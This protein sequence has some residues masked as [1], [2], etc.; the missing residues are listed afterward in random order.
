LTIS[1]EKRDKIMC[2][3][4]NR[5]EALNALAPEDMDGL[6]KA[7]IGF[8]DDP[9]AWVCILTGAGEKAFCT[10]ADM[11]KAVGQ[12]LEA[13]GASR[14]TSGF[15]YGYNGLN[16]WKPIIGAI[17]GYCLAGGLAIALLCDIRICSEN[18]IFGT[19]GTS[20][21]IMP[22]GGQTQR[23]PRVIPLAKALELFFT[24]EN[25]SAQEAYRIGL[26]N[27]VVSQAELMN[28]AWE[29]AEK[30]ARNAPIAIAASKQAC[31]RGLDLPLDQGIKLEV[32]LGVK[33]IST[34]DASEG[35]S[36]FK[37]RRKPRFKGK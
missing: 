5:P 36:A 6:R 13:S 19:V 2:I 16:I 9:D 17:N 21:G 8:R 10:G 34:E 18:A 12:D 22:A 29:M 7:L 25:I 26:V 27:R 37:E 11:I 4:L 35:I 28:S 32:D 24:A 30:I 33:L 15:Y 3:T 23:L 14:D 20:R 1:S 31:I